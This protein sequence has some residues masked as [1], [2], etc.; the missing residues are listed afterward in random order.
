M[1]LSPPFLDITASAPALRGRWLRHAAAVALFLL[2]ALLL[3]TP[4]NLLPFGVL[5]LATSLPGISQLWHAYRQVAAPVRLLAALAVVV[6]GLGVWS[7]GSDGLP[8]RTLDDLSRFLV[9]PWVLLWVCAFRPKMSM[10]WWGAWF[11]L[12]ATLAVAGYQRI[13]G[14]ER[15]DAWTNAIVLADIVLVLMVVLVFCRPPA[16]W[17]WIMVGLGVGGVVI[18]CSGSRGVWPALLA[19][20]VAMAFSIRRGSRHMR[21]A[22]VAGL[23]LVAVTLVLSIPQLRQHTRLDELRS[24]VERIEVGD[25]DSSAGAR[26]ERW[27]VA[28]DVF[29]ERPWS[30]VGFGQFDKA[31][32]RLPDC[33]LPV[34]EARC[35]LGHAHN[36]LAEWAAT[37]GIPGVLLL[38]GIYGVPLVMFVRLHRRSGEAG[39][40]G[41]AAAGVMLVCTYVLCGLTQSMFA[42]QITAGTYAVLVGVLAGLSLAGATGRQRDMA[43]QG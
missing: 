13:N 21:L 15:A 9:M 2:P 32:Q 43:D 37:L 27:Q 8:P 19:L 11:G 18:L 34:P 33:R 14:W 42:H 16:R 26:L 41:P 7:A 38:L 20:L 24:D 3:S 1:S 23:L 30:G 4:L 17:G 39:F 28:W 22:G 35:R 10:L 36:D 12:L 6:L 31:M 29:V 40:H 5:L 25:V